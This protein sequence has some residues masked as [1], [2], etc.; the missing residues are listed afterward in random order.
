MG[1]DIVVVFDGWKSGSAREEQIRRAGLRI[2]YS[3]LADTADSVIKRVVAEKRSE[4][5]VI[6]SDRDIASFAWSAGSVPVSSDTFIRLLESDR[7]AGSPE[8]GGDDDESDSPKK[9]SPRKPSRKEKA[10][11]R[12]L[13]N[14]RQ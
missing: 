5:I 4:W 6:T 13:K 12:A 9:G 1:H 2:I 3:R 8:E 7:G 14:L 11:R 10:L